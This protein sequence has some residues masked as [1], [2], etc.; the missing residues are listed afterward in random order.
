MHIL[1]LNVWLTDPYVPKTP[2]KPQDPN[3]AVHQEGNVQTEV[4]T[5]GKA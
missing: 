5:Q 3:L 1:V 2:Q 4:P